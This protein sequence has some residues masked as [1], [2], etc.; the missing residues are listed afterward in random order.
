MLLVLTTVMLAI[1]LFL[2]VDALRETP[3]ARAILYAITAFF[4]FVYATVWFG[5]RPTAF[6]VEH[7]ALTI[8]W[9]LWQ[10]T[11]PREAVEDARIVSAA[12]FR[13]EYGTGMRIGA[14]GLWGG[15][16]L[17]RTSRETFSMWI[18]RTDAFVIVRV[19]GARAL[20]VTPANPERFVDELSRAR[21]TREA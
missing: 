21:G 6:V 12:A 9:P 3:A 19:R 2:V 7:D 11:I 20:L 16:G 15:F 5:F 1:P 10:R 17:L 14:G 18:S 13:D 4:V 8:A